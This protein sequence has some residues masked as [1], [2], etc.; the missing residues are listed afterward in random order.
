[1]AM[2]GPVIGVGSVVARRDGVDDEKRPMDAPVTMRGERGAGHSKLNS[3]GK[4]P[5][6]TRRFK[7]AE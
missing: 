3:D 5:T 4:L 7:G 1:M 2:S 6:A